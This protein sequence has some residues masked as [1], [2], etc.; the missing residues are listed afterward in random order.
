M[1][2]KTKSNKETVT[3]IIAVEHATEAVKNS[4]NKEYIDQGYTLEEEEVS[5]NGTTMSLKYSKDINP[6]KTYGQWA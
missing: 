4:I 3:R 6:L 5:T 2:K 1:K